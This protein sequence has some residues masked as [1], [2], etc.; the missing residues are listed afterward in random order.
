MKLYLELTQRGIYFMALT[1]NRVM[2][3][4]T[5]AAKNLNRYVVVNSSIKEQNTME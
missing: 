4:K 3:N 5:K 1:T 2:S